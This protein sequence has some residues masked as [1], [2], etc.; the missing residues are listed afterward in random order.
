MWQVPLEH[1]IRLHNID[2][3]LNEA[4]SI[5][6]KVKLSLKVGSDEEIFEFYVTSLGPEKVIF[7]TTL[8]KTSESHNKL[9]RRYYAPRRR[10]GNEP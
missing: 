7:G 2:G 10:S 1:P 6:H 4:G 8:A 5:T 9:A 3:T